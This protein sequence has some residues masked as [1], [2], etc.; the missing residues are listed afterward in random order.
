MRGHDGVM[1]AESSC[2]LKLLCPNT[3]RTW[4]RVLLRSCSDLMMELTSSL[5]SLILISDSLC[6]LIMLIPTPW[7]WNRNSEISSWAQV[8]PEW[9][10]IM[11]VFHLLF[12]LRFHWLWLF[13]L[14][15]SKLRLTLSSGLPNPMHIP[16]GPPQFSSME[17]MGVG[18]NRAKRYSSQ[19]QRA[20]PE[21]APPMHLGVME[22]H[23]YEPSK[24]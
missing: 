3:C 2:S 11:W 13:D 9:I 8:A 1:A 24:T 15:L 20:V 21:P 19:R 5:C 17:E 22:G 6:M 12:S 4:S 14:C 7:W 10:R 16:G 23:Y 18:S